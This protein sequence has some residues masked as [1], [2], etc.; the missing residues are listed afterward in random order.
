MEKEVLN[1]LRPHPNVIYLHH[2]FQDIDALYLNPF[3]P[4]PTQY[5]CQA[6]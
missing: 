4:G 3:G 5:L 2:T 6:N 1:R